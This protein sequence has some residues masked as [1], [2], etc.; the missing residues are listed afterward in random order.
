MNVNLRPISTLDAE[1]MAKLRADWRAGLLPPR[2]IAVKHRLNVDELRIYAAE[3]QWDGSDLTNPIQREHQR[4]LVQ[5]TVADFDRAAGR[6]D[7]AVVDNRR[8]VEQF[9]QILAS[10]TQEQQ[11]EVSSARRYVTRLMHDLEALEPPEV[12]EAAANG[13]AALIG[14]ENPELAKQIRGVASAAN[15]GERLKDIERRAAIVFKLATAIK[16]LIETER[17][18]WGMGKVGS[19]QTND[20]DSLLDELHRIQQEA[21]QQA[22]IN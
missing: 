14:E 22:R 1:S 4:A 13:V 9:G 10:V 20:Y 12:D 21:R 17:L 16:T 19:Q 5:R 2:T 3:H 11:R 7:P 18:V 15:V 6:T 8:L